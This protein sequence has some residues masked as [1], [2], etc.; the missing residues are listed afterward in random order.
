LIVAA[1][2]GFRR[3]DVND[4]GTQTEQD[5]SD[6]N[7][8]PTISSFDPD[9][10]DGMQTASDSGLNDRAS[11][12]ENSIR[13]ESPPSS[14]VDLLSHIKSLEVE[15]RTAQIV[16]AKL[17]AD[18]RGHAKHVRDME[19][20]VYGSQELAK[21]LNIADQA[22]TYLLARYHAVLQ[23]NDFLRSKIASFDCQNKDLWDAAFGG[24]SQSIVPT[25]LEWVSA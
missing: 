6:Q 2:H 4:Q 14:D 18:G 9:R 16:N 3:S 5:D 1:K 15:L 19:K 22:N 13:L 17:N 12:S 23:E 20:A 24:T 8:S 7:S 21:T 10:Q 11:K 25:N